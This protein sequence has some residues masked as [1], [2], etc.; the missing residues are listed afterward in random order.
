MTKLSEVMTKLSEVMTKLSEVMTKL[1]EVMTKL[2][3]V[4]TKLSEVMTKLSHDQAIGTPSPR[5]ARIR[6]SS[7]RPGRREGG[8]SVAARAPR[9]RE[10]NPRKTTPEEGG[11]MPDLS[12]KDTSMCAPPSAPMRARSGR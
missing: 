7:K 12:F 11:A 6:R 3:E 1:S 2:S 4:M 5:S 9:Q 10:Y 8:L